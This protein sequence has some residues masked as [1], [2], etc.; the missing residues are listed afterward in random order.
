MIILSILL[1]PFS[2]LYGMAIS[3]RHW[4][5]NRG[6]L[7]SHAFKTP[8]ICVGNLSLGG[9][10]KTP[11]V[12]LLLRHYNT[13]EAFN[14]AILSRGYGRISKGLVHASE[15][16][17]VEDLGDEPFQIAQSYP[18]NPLV[19][20]ASRIEGMSYL[21]GL[22]SK[23][24]HLVILDDALQ[25]RAIQAS[26]TIL[27][28]TFSK[29]FYKDS[30]IPSGTLRDLPSRAKTADLI[31]VTKCPENMSNSQRE[32][33]LTH[34]PKHSNQKICFS[35]LRYNTIW[36]G[37]KSDLN[38]S[39][40][41][42]VEINLITAIAQ[43]EPLLRYL[44]KLGVKYR[45]WRFRD[46]HFFTANEVAE[47]ENLPHLVCTEKDFVKLKDRLDNIHYIGV[48]HAFFED[49]AK[50]FYSALPAISI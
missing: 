40:F 34:I 38:G 15:H 5:Y 32:T 37:V 28:T 49:D 46:H 23:A 26:Y 9:T 1:R 47:L 24:P 8:S 19:V 41:V 27:L 48:E 17:T 4:A 20:S 16:A 11:M 2:Y 6:V 12:A 43:P 33:K 21:E 44:D 36:R 29:P 39:D 14:T 35:Y 45:H 10:G 7:K 22:A 31:V 25:H 18:K 30:L 42:G 13:I 3:I 50:V